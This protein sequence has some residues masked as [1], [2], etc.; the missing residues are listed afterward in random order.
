MFWFWMNIPL[1]LVF[2]GLWAGIPLWKTLTSWRAELDAKHAELAAALA[3]AAP[4]V[5]ASA[6][7]ATAVPEVGRLAYAGAGAPAD[8]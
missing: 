1:M 5:A 3:V 8:G 6:A 2:F 7:A 4:T